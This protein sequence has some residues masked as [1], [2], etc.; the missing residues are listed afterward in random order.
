M[1]ETVPEENG[2]QQ[3]LKGFVDLAKLP[4]ISSV[5]GSVVPT[6]I[7]GSARR[8]SLVYHPPQTVL[9]WRKNRSEAPWGRC[10]ARL[11][12]GWAL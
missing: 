4:V 2:D 10:Q 3:F 11:R 9:W 7:L 5:L 8:G 1:G 6:Q 12:C